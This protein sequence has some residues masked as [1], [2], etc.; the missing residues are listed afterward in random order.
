LRTRQRAEQESE[1]FVA[2][3]KG[4]LAHRDC[5]DPAPSADRQMH[6]LGQLISDAWRVM[7]AS[8]ALRLATTSSAAVALVVAVWFWPHQAHATVTL[9]GQAICTAC[10]LHET[11]AHL[12]AIRVRQGDRTNVYYVSAGQL[13]IMRLGDYCIA[14]LPVVVTGATEVHGGRW[15]IE[16]ENAQRAPSA[17]SHHERVL[18]PF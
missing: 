5:A 16:V 1:A 9:E 17:T 2:E 7:R 12:P 15:T 10:A 3:V 4:R 8:R 13:A 18:F 6:A 14:P 11:H